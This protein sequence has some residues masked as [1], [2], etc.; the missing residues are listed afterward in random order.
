MDKFGRKMVCLFSCVPA[1]ISWILFIFAK[2]I[3]TIYTARFIAGIAAGLTTTSLIYISEL[4]HPQIRPMLLCLNSVFVSLG[5][6]ITCC[7]A[8][9]LDWHKMAIVFLALECCIFF[10]LFFVPES[11]YWLACFGSGMLDEK[12]IR[13]MKHSLMRLNRRQKVSTTQRLVISI[14]YR[15]SMDKRFLDLW[16]GVLAN[17]GDNQKPRCEW[18]NIGQ[19]RYMY[20]KLLSEIQVSVRL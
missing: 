8:V 5:I 3:I 20:K 7:L 17:R 10:A 14:H 4:S 6:L 16:T 18:W 12:R 9:L 15:I 1:I 13:E 11:P 2:S 19:C